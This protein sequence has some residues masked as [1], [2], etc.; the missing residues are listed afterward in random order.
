MSARRE[1]AWEGIARIHISS[2]RLLQ[3]L[4]LSQRGIGQEGAAALAA[5]VGHLPF[6]RELRLHSCYELGGSGAEV[7]AAALA[8]ADDRPKGL[9][10]GGRLPHL[11]AISSSLLLQ[12][13]HAGT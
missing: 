1:R 7:L 11:H 8:S 5:A 6:L 2:L 3:V 9:Q 13:R 12:A 10:V 4:D